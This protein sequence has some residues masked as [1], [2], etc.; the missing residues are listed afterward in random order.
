[1]ILQ[2][3]LEKAKGNFITFQLGRLRY[4]RFIGRLVDFDVAE[5]FIEVQRVVSGVN[6][7]LPTIFTM[8]SEEIVECVK[9]CDP[10]KPHLVESH[11]DQIHYTILPKTELYN[12]L[13]IISLVKIDA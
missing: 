11:I 8:T 7:R 3:Y 10:T 12:L 2:R 4:E 1:M 9:I 13:N 5:G 6:P